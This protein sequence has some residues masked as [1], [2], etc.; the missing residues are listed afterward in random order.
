MIKS[1]A[2][3]M[4]LGECLLGLSKVFVINWRGTFPVDDASIAVNYE[5][6][7]TRF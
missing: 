2:C 4:V 1:S 3:R 5:R 7:M 6:T